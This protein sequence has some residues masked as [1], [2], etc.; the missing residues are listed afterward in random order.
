MSFLK[1]RQ[2]ATLK[3]TN[4]CP[5]V[6]QIE[7]IVAAKNKPNIGDESSSVISKDISTIDESLDETFQPDSTI[8]SDKAAHAS[9]QTDEFLVSPYEH[10]FPYV[11]PQWIPASN[12]AQ[13]GD[14]SSSSSKIDPLP[15]NPY[16]IL[17]RH[18]ET[19]YKMAQN[20]GKM[21]SQE[22]EIKRLKV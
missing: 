17:D 4:S 14:T 11:L 1:A 3:R 18:I 20:K 13:N 9:V 12:S 8:L 5:D 2:K 15:D 19:A 22:Q 6:H 7:E 10:L 16:D 21:T